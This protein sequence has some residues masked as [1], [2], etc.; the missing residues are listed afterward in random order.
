MNIVKS[1]LTHSVRSTKSVYLQLL[2]NVSVKKVS[3]QMLLVT[4]LISTS[5]LLLGIHVRK[6]RNA[7]IE[8]EQRLAKNLL[9]H[10]S[11]FETVTQ[12]SD[13]WFID[14]KQAVN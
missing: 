14:S 11:R 7:L 12:N 5:V 9:N 10:D 2:G 3:S 8:K 1:A 4:A 6:P 13:S